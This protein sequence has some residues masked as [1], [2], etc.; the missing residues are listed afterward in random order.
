MEYWGLARNLAA[1]G[2]FTITPDCFGELICSVD[3][4]Y[5]IG[6]GAREK[7]PNCFLVCLLEGPLRIEA[8]GL[9]RCVAARLWPWTVGR[10]LAHDPDLPPRGWIDATGIFGAHLAR[11]AEVARR[12]DWEAFP[13]VFDQVLIEEIG[14]WKRDDAGMDMVAPF[15]DGERC[16]TAMVANERRTTKRQVER[17]IRALTGT[18]PKQLATLSRFQKVRDAIWADPSINLA[19]LAFDAGY[20][21]QPHMT[22]EFRRYSGQSPS[23]FA[24]EVVAKKKW[25]AVHDVAFVQERTA[26]DG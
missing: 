18:S 9:V 4:L 25:M 11:V 14:R 6:G 10:F 17:R 7:L 1:M 5:A 2:G 16:G 15:L 26:S 3:D 22:R 13:G 12:R 8:D 21:D 23:R 20:S 19:R 24:R